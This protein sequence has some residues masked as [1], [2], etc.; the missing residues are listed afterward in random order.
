LQRAHPVPIRSEAIEPKRH[1]SRSVAIQI[2]LFL[3]GFGGEI[4]TSRIESVAYRD[5]RTE[6]DDKNKAEQEISLHLK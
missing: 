6:T 3:A 2:E 4:V 5:S 1:S